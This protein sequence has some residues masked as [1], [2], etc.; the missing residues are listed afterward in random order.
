[1]GWVR[2]G[3]VAALGAVLIVDALVMSPFPVLQF[4]VALIMLGLVPIDAIID[5]ATRPAR[6]QADIDHLRDVMRHPDEPG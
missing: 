1:M 4:V 5:A 2:R 6:D 3:I